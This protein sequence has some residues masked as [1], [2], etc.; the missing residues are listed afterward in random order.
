MFIS[1]KFEGS[2]PNPAAKGISSA[3]LN[4]KQLWRRALTNSMLGVGDVHKWDHLENRVFSYPRWLSPLPTPRSCGE[5]EHL[6]WCP[7]MGEKSAAF[8]EC[9]IHF[10]QASLPQEVPRP[11]ALQHCG[12]LLCPGLC[13]P[14]SNLVI[15]P[16]YIYFKQSAGH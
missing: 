10:T 11:H 4:I 9:S 1:S 13:I 6:T 15:L 14:T 12:G 7:R 8:V 2:L 5:M 16:N 3:G